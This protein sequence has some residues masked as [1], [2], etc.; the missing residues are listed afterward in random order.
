[1]EDLVAANGI[2]VSK[3]SLDD[4]QGRNYSRF[5]IFLREFS[6]WPDI[7]LEADAIAPRR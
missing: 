2:F 3:D 5:A 6:I 7:K 1:V 4:G